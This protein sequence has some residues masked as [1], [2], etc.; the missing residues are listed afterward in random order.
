MCILGKNLLSN[1]MCLNDPVKQKMVDLVEMLPTM[2]T[3]L[4]CFVLLVSAEVYHHNEG[5]A[6]HMGA[7]DWQG[8]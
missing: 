1:S 8:Q 4:K 3:G 7:V 6:D 2:L 5:F